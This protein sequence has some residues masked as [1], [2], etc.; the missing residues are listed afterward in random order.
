M[1]VGAVPIRRNV[2]STT[3]W[4]VLVHPLWWYCTIGLVAALGAWWV[5]RNGL[6]VGNDSAT[7]VAVAENIRAG[8]GATSPFFTSIDGVSFDDAVRLLG[9]SPLLL[10]PPLYS[11]MLAFVADLTGGTVPE[12]ARVITIVSCGVIATTTAALTRRLAFGAWG[13]AVAAAALATTYPW[14]AWIG[15]A[16]ASDAPFL[17]MSG[18]AALLLLAFDDRRDAATLTLFGFVAAVA[19]MTRFVGVG[20]PLAAVLVILTARDVSPRWRRW[21][22]VGACVPLLPVMFW[23][24]TRARGVEYHAHDVELQFPSDAIGHLGRATWSWFW[25]EGLDAPWTWLLA[26]AIIGLGSLVVVRLGLGAADALRRRAAA[27][28]GAMGS[29]PSFG[30][31]VDPDAGRVTLCL[32]GAYLVTLLLS[33]AT[34]GKYGTLDLR[35]TLPLMPPV[36]A[37]TVAACWRLVRRPQADP[38]RNGA[39]ARW[40][41]VVPITL[42]S[43][44]LVV[45]LIAQLVGVPPKPPPIDDE[46]LGSGPSELRD[47]TDDYPLVVASS[48]SAFYAMTGRASVPLPLPYR[49]STGAP[50]PD[51]DD[52][53]AEVR[54]LVHDRQAVV[55]YLLLD[56]VVNP[57]TVPPPGDVAEK[58]D[59]Q[60]LE[61]VDDLVSLIGV[62]PE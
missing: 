26:L 27:R 11:W 14:L 59:A 18:C 23:M 21:S 51:Y 10:W 1:A 56:A 60:T 3:N 24:A 7:Y 6:F 58:L 62:R 4:A 29:G 17:A 33:S 22:L 19:C 55:A 42:V 57:G 15:S 52:E 53:M 54:E 34:V 30:A 12:A 38:T 13:A 40:A 50:N 5:T 20:L 35:I 2:R 48:P 39:E 61:P 9:H 25:P 8:K 16:I 36:V 37:L 44:F 49:P 41:G 32:V 47:A 45:V 46:A 43:V 28:E 31:I